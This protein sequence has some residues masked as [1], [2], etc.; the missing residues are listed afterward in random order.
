[1]R[2][3]EI[4]ESLTN[5]RVRPS[6]PCTRRRM[7]VPSS[8]M[9]LSR[10]IARAGCVGSGSKTATTWPCSQPARTSPPSPRAPNA[11]ERESRRMDLPAPVSP[12][13]TKRPDAKS[14]SSLSIRTMSR[15]ESWTSIRPRQSVGQ[16]VALAANSFD[17]QELV[18]S[19]GSWPPLFSS[20]TESLYHWL[21][22]K[23][24]PRTAAAVCASS[25][26]PMA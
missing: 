26:M 13:S 19:R 16:P 10:K 1:M 23:L 4:G 9:A 3:A 14:I 2:L 7:I 20:L 18:F 22:G 6:A 12:V 17:I 21:S 24:C 25:T 5:A 11:S 8:S 15:I